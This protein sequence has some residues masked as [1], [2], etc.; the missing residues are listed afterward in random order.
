MILE[1]DPCD[2]KT[3]CPEK[4]SCEVIE[5]EAVCVCLEGL[6]GANCDELGNLCTLGGDEKKCDWSG[7]ECVPLSGGEFKCQCAE[8]FEGNGLS[9]VGKY[10]HQITS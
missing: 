2:E 10:H 9:C 5:G 3:D 6:T 1:E 8:G 4:S 7:A